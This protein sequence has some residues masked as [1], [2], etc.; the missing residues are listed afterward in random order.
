MKSNEDQ[1]YLNGLWQFGKDVDE[2]KLIFGK[3]LEDLNFGLLHGAVAEHFYFPIKELAA[4]LLN[5]RRSQLA[6]RLG[7]QAHLQRRG[8]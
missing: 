8:R 6:D 7:L 5:F 1:T 4:L 2:S 3:T